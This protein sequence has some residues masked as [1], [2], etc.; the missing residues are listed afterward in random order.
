MNL[1]YTALKF[2]LDVSHWLGLLVVAIWA[3]LRTKDNDNAKAVQAVATELATF[4]QASTDANH[5]QNTRLTI[6]E[7]TADHAPT[8]REVGEVAAAVAEMRSKLEG[9]S[10]LLERVERQTGLIQE[11]LMRKT[12]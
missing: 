3:Y 12:R 6:L 7:Q 10:K 11:H 9:H 1:D 4:I 5:E 8:G 2:W